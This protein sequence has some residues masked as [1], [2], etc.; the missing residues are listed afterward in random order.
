MRGVEMIRRYL[1]L[2]A[3]LTLV[4]SLGAA[5]QENRSRGPVVRQVDHIL[6]ES[7]KPNALFDFFVDTLQLPIAWPMAD[8]GGF[9][10]G[11]VGAGDVSIEVFRYADPKKRPAGKTE[12]AH[13]SGLAFEPFL[14]SSAL[15]ELKVRNISHNPPESYTSTLP[16]GSQGILWTT[17]ALPSL[18]RPGMSI[19]LYEYSPAFLK[20]DVRRKQMGNRLALNKGGP[21]GFKSI[22]EIVIAA[23]D[24]KS[25]TAEWRKMLGKQ[26]TSG[27]WR[28][29]SG[30]AIRLVRSSQD[31]IQEI[32]FEV[33]S[34]N[35]AKTFLQKNGLLGAVSSK[36]VFLNPLK[37]QGLKIRLTEQ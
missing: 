24:L 12:G 32:V 6:V 8:N 1:V 23:T 5:P 11:G 15:Y 26:T 34:L 18:S 27:N 10:S 3:V 30:P 25:D 28:T 4:L 2:I 31:C 9:L 7:D 22:R 14:L 37:I 33:E 36:E 17:V 20:V 13:Y 19:F 35:N 16:K 29:V 21:L